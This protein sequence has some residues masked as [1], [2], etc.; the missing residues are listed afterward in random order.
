M[1]AELE[2]LIQEQNKQLTVIG[3]QLKEQINSPEFRQAM[4]EIYERFKKMMDDISRDVNMAKQS[5]N[6]PAMSGI[7]RHKKRGSTYTI[8][9]MIS[10][11]NSGKPIVDG[12]LL[13]V[14]ENTETKA[15]Y[16]RRLEEFNDGRFE[17]VSHVQKEEELPFWPGDV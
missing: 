11:Q 12:E 7:F 5:S 16:G 17:R 6:S 8:D 2:R 1:S 13:L 9:R 15:A 10:V 4:S 3:N 14:Y